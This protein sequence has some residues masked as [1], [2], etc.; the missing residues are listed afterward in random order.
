MLLVDD[1][2]L[3]LQGLKYI[4]ECSLPDVK[5]ICT[6]SSGREA[7]SLITSQ[8]F[9][10]CVLDLELPDMS[11]LDV[12]ACIREKNA[13]TRII[14]N[15]MHE[16]LWCIKE[17]LQRQVDG[18]LFKSV[19]PSEMLEAIRRILRGKTYYC[20]QVR[21]TRAKMERSDKQRRDTLTPRELDVLKLLSEGKTTQE[22]ARELCVS[23]NTVDTHRRHLLDKLGARNVVDL[24]M[25]AI[26]K[27][28]ITAY[29]LCYE[30]GYCYYFLFCSSQVLAAVPM[31]PMTNGRKTMTRRQGFPTMNTHWTVLLP[32]R[33]LRIHSLTYPPIHWN[34]YRWFSTPTWL[35][36]RSK[37]RRTR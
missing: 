3:V 2:E 35:L 28:I 5:H 7:I 6:A 17:L 13:G 34:P 25:T 19:Y 30:T 10:L 26:A 1:H 23:T 4:I 27:G 20:E 14:V 36:R 37:L 29:S 32:S 31:I 11:G 22:I 18:I 21:R 24:L 8:H 16:E 33:V 9:H 12:I 15:T